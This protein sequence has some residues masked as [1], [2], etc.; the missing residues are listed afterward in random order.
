[1]PEEETGV[2]VRRPGNLAANAQG[3]GS[4]EIGFSLLVLLLSQVAEAAQAAD[5]A[6]LLQAQR[7]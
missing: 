3:N 5:D 2:S 7:P 6:L 1:L 4:G